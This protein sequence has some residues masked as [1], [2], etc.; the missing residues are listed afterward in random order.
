MRALESECERKEKRTLST[1]VTKSSPK[2]ASRA[3]SHSVKTGTTIGLE[4]PVAQANSAAIAFEFTWQKKGADQEA[5]NM[6]NL[7]VQRCFL[8]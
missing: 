3:T 6:S 4:S 5:S 8:L 7:V 1:A 2:L